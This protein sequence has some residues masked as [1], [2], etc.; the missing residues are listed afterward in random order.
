M[1]VKNVFLL[2][3]CLLLATQLTNVSAQVETAIICGK[4]TDVDGKPIEGASVVVID[5]YR[6]R[7]LSIL[8]TDYSG[9][10]ELAVEAEFPH[11]YRVYAYKEENNVIV[12][13]PSTIEKTLFPKSG[14]RISL[15]LKL[16]PGAALNITG[17]AWNVFTARYST[18]L[19]IQVVD[20]ASGKILSSMVDP[21]VGDYTPF[22]GDNVTS[23]FVNPKWLS[24]LFSPSYWTVVIIPSNRPVELRVM[25]SQ[26]GVADQV[27]IVRGSDDKPFVLSQ[28]AIEKVDITRNAYLWSLSKVEEASRL[29]WEKIYD[30]ERFGFFLLP[31]KSEARVKVDNQISR[32]REK[33]GE[34]IS[35]ELQTELQRSLREA[36][37]YA[38]RYIIGE[39][40]SMKNISEKGA[41][42]LPMFLTVFSIMLTLF[43]TEKSKLMIRLPLFIILFVIVTGCFY[44][45]YPGIPLILTRFSGAFY[46]SVLTAFLSGLIF[47]S[48]FQK[49][50]HETGST[51]KVPFRSA[52]AVA[53]TLGKRYV[54]LRKFSS[55]LII[56][57]ICI[58]IAT[59]TTLTSVSSIFGLNR[60]TVGSSTGEWAFIKN[61]GEIEGLFTPIDTI[62]MKRI[63]NET[64]IKS[65]SPKMDSL[66]T[67]KQN[68]VQ[69]ISESEKALILGIIGIV[70]ELDTKYVPLELAIGNYITD[71]S[72]IMISYATAQRLRVKP[73]DNV[74]I[75]FS[76][77]GF[78]YEVPVKIA[79]L[80]RDD[81]FNN[82]K[83]LNGEPYAPYVLLEDKLALCNASQVII[84]SL[85]KALELSSKPYSLPI[86][87][88]RII[89]EFENPN[90]PSVMDFIQTQAWA[91]G[92]HVW[93]SR[94]GTLTRYYLGMMIEIRFLDII[95]PLIIMMMFLMRL[96]YDVVD[97]RRKEIFIYTLLG[98][99][100]MH[101]ALVFLAESATM[102]LL[103]GG[104]GYLIGL[105]FFRGMRYIS[106]AVEVG[107]SENL[108]WEASILSI[109]IGLIISMASAM[110][111]ALKA[112]SLAVPS[113]K[114]KVKLSPEEE[115]KRYEEIYK[116]FGERVTFI[117][118]RVKR[119]E[120]EFLT[121]YLQD[122]LKERTGGFSERVE[123]LG[124]IEVVKAPDG[125]E[126]HS[127]SF[128]YVVIHRGQKFSTWNKIRLECKPEEDSF[129]AYL[130]SIAEQEGM[131]EIVRE[132]AMKVVYDISID[133]TK[134]R[135]SPSKSPP[136]L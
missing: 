56:I 125:T 109:V 68:E 115:V 76:S 98:F 71:H 133:W 106:E 85:Q 124:Q 32:A 94:D 67:I 17:E 11:S 74:T 100:P 26:P 16:V 93:L 65:I 72:S 45:L 78:V 35:L 120:I 59:A 90:D 134:R 37:I 54:K 1:R 20:P 2:I 25:A 70:P 63:G 122:K 103:G 136:R 126:T 18:S 44:Y 91:R 102:G 7:T 84:M 117:P 4:V 119:G 95:P 10:Y 5:W 108:H 114:R 51:I 53:F 86:S 101:I 58:L 77:G 39:I 28:G 112:A 21:R 6:Q 23:Y 130:H 123:D 69:L 82:K 52:L 105:G 30:A 24:P 40:E 50:I 97:R 132:R 110:P 31:L 9:Y 111:P 8:K 36:Y 46:L 47:M 33:I 135:P 99:N 88:S 48:L 55:T 79:G 13:A 49:I 43:I 41:L 34:E 128:R 96:M 27:F 42:F 19:K 73:G 12:Y 83:D 64:N 14:E 107:V 15:D 22:Y 81:V 89:V 66:P 3:A 129:R 57:S 116:A 87:I 127:I 29:M 38:T 92:F 113:L 104:F 62:T 131:P 118:L 60:E 80:F 61:P 75:R 121:G